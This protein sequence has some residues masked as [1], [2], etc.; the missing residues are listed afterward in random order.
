MPDRISLARL[1]TDPALLEHQGRLLLSTPLGGLPLLHRQLQT[2]RVAGIRRVELCV[3]PRE[4]E[5]VTAAVAASAPVPGVSLKV[6]ATPGG[7]KPGDEPALLLPANLLID[8]RALQQLLATA[9]GVNPIVCVDRA[10]E[11]Y[12]AGLKSP[13]K[14]GAP[15]GGDARVVDAETV[16]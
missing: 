8:P 4:R 14:V 11:Q 3:P 6:V 7:N 5:W 9:D 12:D 2:L 15:G 16:D 1:P 13:Y 10:P